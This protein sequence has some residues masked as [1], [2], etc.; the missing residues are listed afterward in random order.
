MKRSMV[1]AG[2]LMKT[3]FAG[4]RSILGAG[5]AYDEA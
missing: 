5:I 4:Q 2:R 1:S 3:V